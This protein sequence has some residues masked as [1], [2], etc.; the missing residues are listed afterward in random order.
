MKMMFGEFTMVDVAALDAAPRDAA[1]A[2]AVDVSNT[3]DAAMQKQAS[4]ELCKK[5]FIIFSFGFFSL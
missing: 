1:A 3:T 2:P 5:D 4:I